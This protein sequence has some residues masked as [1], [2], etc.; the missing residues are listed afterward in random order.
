MKNF[1]EDAEAEFWLLL[2]AFVSYCGKAFERSQYSE[3]KQSL[4]KPKSFLYI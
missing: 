4:I 1:S 2:G 3:K